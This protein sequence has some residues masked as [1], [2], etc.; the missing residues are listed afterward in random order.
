M[1]DLDPPAHLVP[2]VISGDEHDHTVVDE[3]TALE[4]CLGIVL[5]LDALARVRRRTCE[6]T[7]SSLP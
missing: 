7:P 4:L 1:Y 3:Y 5:V 6:S 2:F